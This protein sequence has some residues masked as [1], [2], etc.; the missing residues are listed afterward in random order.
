MTVTP[1]TFSLVSCLSI[2]NGSFL[3][4]CFSHRIMKSE[5][6][7]CPSFL[8]AYIIINN[9]IFISSIIINKIL[10]TPVTVLEPMNNKTIGLHGIQPYFNLAEEPIKN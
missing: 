9:I 10:T 3:L 8:P 2:F 6:V 5:L 7:I 1:K 4:L